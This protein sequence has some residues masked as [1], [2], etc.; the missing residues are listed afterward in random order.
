MIVAEFDR[1]EGEVLCSAYLH[2][3]AP[4]RQTVPRA[5]VYALLSTLGVW[6]GDQILTIVRDAAC[7]IQG[8]SPGKEAK[9]VRGVNADL[10]N[11]V[12]GELLAVD[13]KRHQEHIK[14]EQ[15]HVFGFELGSDYFYR[16]EGEALRVFIVNVMGLF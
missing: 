6:D 13:E 10:W 16:K 9:N 3:A 15:F 11:M 14:G 7:K 1:K 8:M 5:D 4:G 2:I 12:Y